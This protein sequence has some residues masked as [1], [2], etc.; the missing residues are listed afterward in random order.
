MQIMISNKNWWSRK[1][2]LFCKVGIST[3]NV[4]YDIG[5]Y[6][7]VWNLTNLKNFETYRCMLADADYYRPLA[8]L[9]FAVPWVYLDCMRM[10]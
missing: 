4:S 5:L 9:K 1:D 2:S 10:Q 3:F 8:K 7:L 6:S